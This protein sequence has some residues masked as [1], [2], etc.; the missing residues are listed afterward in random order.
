[1]PPISDYLF[2]LLFTVTIELIVA[3]ILGYRSKESILSV[4][5][6]N[7]ITN[8]LA[9]YLVLVNSYVSVL[10]ENTLIILIE[11][12]VVFAEWGLLIYALRREPKKLLL[13]SIMMNLVS[14]L[15]GIVI[16]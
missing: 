15:V 16:F 5:L 14:Y 10:P 6:V 13:L 2:A 11:I 12:G 1:M 7:V 8:P 4:I 3:A 9:N